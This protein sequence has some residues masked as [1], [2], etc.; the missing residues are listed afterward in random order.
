LQIGNKYR[1]G[2]YIVEVMQGNQRRYLK[3]IKG[4]E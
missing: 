1:P 2:T 3:L 4:S